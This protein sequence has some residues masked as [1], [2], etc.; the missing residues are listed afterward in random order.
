MS[1]N[2]WLFQDGTLKHKLHVHVCRGVLAA[3]KS[4][5]F[6]KMRTADPQLLVGSD[7]PPRQ[8]ARLFNALQWVAPHWVAPLQRHA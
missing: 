1:E 7:A 4:S 8:G 3:V 2:G 6:S 5:K